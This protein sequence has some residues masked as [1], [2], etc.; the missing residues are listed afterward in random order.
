MKV[1]MVPIGQVF[2]RFPRLVRDVAKAR[3]KEVHCTFRAQRPIWTR[4]SSTR[5]A[6][7]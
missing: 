1:R 4:R 7:R 5:S 6:S 3:G 2:D